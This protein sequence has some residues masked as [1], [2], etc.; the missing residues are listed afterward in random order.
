MV[1][2]LCFK[3]V[4][5]VVI[6]ADADDDDAAALFSF[7]L[8]VYFFLFFSSLRFAFVYSLHFVRLFGFVDEPLTHIYMNRTRL[9][10]CQID[11]TV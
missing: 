9:W 8:S 10:M 11:S 7:F 3:F 4:V 2:N 5:V 6:G 1:F